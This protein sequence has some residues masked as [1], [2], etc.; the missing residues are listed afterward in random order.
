[1]AQILNC[2]TIQGHTS[3]VAMARIQ[4]FYWT[5]LKMNWRVWTVF[6]YII[7]NYVPTQVQ[8]ELRLNALHLDVATVSI[9]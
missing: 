9:L 7:V 5:S 4:K 2:A 8:K 1:M 6:Q 3:E